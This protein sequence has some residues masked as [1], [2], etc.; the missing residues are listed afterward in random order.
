VIDVNLD[1]FYDELEI[2]MKETLPLLPEGGNVLDI[3]CGK[4]WLTRLLYEKFKGS[5]TGIDKNEDNIKDC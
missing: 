2:V 5:V 4:G 1:P 3:G